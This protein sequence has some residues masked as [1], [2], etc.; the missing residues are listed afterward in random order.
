VLREYPLGDAQI[1]LLSGTTKNGVYRI[2]ITINQTAISGYYFTQFTL[3]DFAN[4]SVLYSDISSVAIPA[5]TPGHSI[6]I[7]GAAAA[8]EIYAYA[9]TLDLGEGVTVDFGTVATG[10]SSSKTI[11]IEN[12]GYT[13]LSDLAVTV[14]GAQAL[15]YSVTAIPSATLLPYGQLTFTLT[16]APTAAGSRQATMRIFSNDPGVPSPMNISLTGNAPGN[17]L[18]WRQQ[19]F[20]SPNNTA[21]GANDA[22]PNKNGIVNL[23]EYAL[24]GNPVNATTGVSVLPVLSLK[25]PQN[26][27]QLTFK[28]YPAN[29][30]VSI[31]VQA[32][33]DLAGPWTTLATSTSGGAFSMVTAGTTIV[34]TPVANAVTTSVCD[35]FPVNDPVHKRR[36]MRIEV[37][38]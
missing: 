31:H 3:Y 36:F 12:I 37:V 6:Q 9:E 35:V 10:A 4:N 15:D 26:R 2:P 27:L 29:N 25:M 11:T 34:N 8:P 14:D 24:G 1:T 5:T 17:I 23:L 20:S 38:Q 28:Y 18:N 16:F 21:N 22:D 33:D 30:D 7:I 19:Y 32:A 13:G